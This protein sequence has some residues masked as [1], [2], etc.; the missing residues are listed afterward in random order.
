MYTIK[1]RFYPPFLSSDAISKGCPVFDYIL[2][3]PN[4]Q[5]TTLR[6]TVSANIA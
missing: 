5:A 3:T 4:L 2:F 1:R 6:K